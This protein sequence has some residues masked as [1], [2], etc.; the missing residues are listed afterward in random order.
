MVI[1]VLLGILIFVAW[2]IWFIVNKISQ[3]LIK[4]V[5]RKNVSEMNKYLGRMKYFKMSKVQFSIGT[6]LITNQ[7]LA[8][9]DDHELICILEVRNNLIKEKVY[10]Y[11]VLNSSEIAENGQSIIEEICLL[12]IFNVTTNPVYK[13]NFMP[14]GLNGIS[15]KKYMEVTRS[16]HDLLSIIM[17]RNQEEGLKA[18]GKY[19]A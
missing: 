6:D 5:N 18:K 10:K 13:F 12:V 9:D 19:L 17:K 15:Y 3:F 11:E 7:C 2:A 8:I 16:W 1:T 4:S 14:Y